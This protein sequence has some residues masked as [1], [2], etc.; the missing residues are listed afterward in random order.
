[1]YNYR[2]ALSKLFILAILFSPKFS[3][4]FA[5]ES[6]AES[7]AEYAQ[8]FPTFTNRWTRNVQIPEA[9]VLTEVPDGLSISGGWNVTAASKFIWQGFDLSDGG[10]AVQ[11]EGYISIGNFSAIIW[12]NYDIDTG[13]FDEHDLYGEY[14]WSIKA[15]SL[16]TGYAY[17][18]YPQNFPHRDAWDATQEVYVSISYDH[19]IN[20]SLS[21]N[22]DFD[23]GEGIY[24]TL[25]VSHGIEI[26]EG[27]FSVGTNLFIHDNYFE[28]SGIPSAEFNA[29]YEYT[30]GS[31]TITPAVSYFLAWDNNEYKGVNALSDETL[32]SINIAQ[33]F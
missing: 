16:T 23:E 32:F 22:W 24:A 20:P 21:I 9:E 4:V 18:E 28:L 17:Y 6:I 5:D 3:T 25:A 2:F 19:P 29:S 31:V 11:P 12:S 7:S 33:D 1:M 10:S 14:A 13:K 15:L 27:N 26:F 30:I 8:T